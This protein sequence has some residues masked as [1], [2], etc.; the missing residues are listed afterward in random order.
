MS[1]ARPGAVAVAAASMFACAGLPG[2]SSKPNDGLAAE[3]RAG[4]AALEA[5]LRDR[6]TQPA[7]RTLPGDRTC[8]LTS[9]GQLRA[10][11]LPDGALT[12]ALADWAPADHMAADGLDGTQFGRQRGPT[13]CKV[14][15]F[16]DLVD[17][18]TFETT[19][20]R[21]EVACG[22]LEAVR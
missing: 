3:T 13:T 2:V 4:C 5:V 12:D 17:M 22:P 7:Q 8:R 6:F 16:W 10:G 11:G 18:D 21:V 14:G 15:V 20:E 9:Q 19:N 1:R